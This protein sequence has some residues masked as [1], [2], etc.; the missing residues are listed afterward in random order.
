MFFFEGEGEAVIDGEKGFRFRSGPR[1]RR[2]RPPAQ[3]RQ[4]EPRIM[5]SRCAGSCCRA[6]MAA[7]MTSS[8]GSAGRAPPGEPAP[9]PFPRPADVERIEAE[10]VFT[11]L[12]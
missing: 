4:P 8:P 7:S 12:E 11:K 6:A 3:V 9:A 1:L 10:T 5:S 2:R